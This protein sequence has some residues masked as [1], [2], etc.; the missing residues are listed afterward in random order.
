MCVRELAS[1]FLCFMAWRFRC[2]FLLVPVPAILLTSSLLLTQPAAA[3]TT[4]NFGP[5]DD[6]L[7]DPVV[8][9]AVNTVLR[10]DAVMRFTVQADIPAGEFIRVEIDNVEV[11]RLSGGGTCND[12]QNFSLTIP[13][14]TLAP[15]VA[16]GSLAI[17]FSASTP[18]FG[19]GGGCVNGIGPFSNVTTSFNFA[20]LGSLSFTTSIDRTIRNFVSRRADQITANEPNLASRLSAISKPVRQGSIKDTGMKLG[21]TN[22]NMTFSASLRNVAAAN[23]AKRGGAVRTGRESNGRMS[24]GHGLPGTM[25]SSRFDVWIEGKLAKTDNDTADSTLGLLY[26]GAD[27]R[28]SHSLVVGLL[29]QFDWSDE[30]DDAVNADIDG[31][32]WML[33]PYMAA[34]LHKNILF[35]SRIAWGRSD[36]DFTIGSSTGSFDTDRWLVKGQLTGDFQNNG[37]HLAPHVAVLYFEEDQ[38][39]T[40]DSLGNAIGAQ[41]V[42]L[43]RVTFG[44]KISTTLHS[45]NRVISPFVAV[46]GIWDFEKDDTV[47]AA[48][49]FAISDSD[50]RGRLEAG[51]SVRGIGG[52]TISGEGFYDGIGAKDF[53]A[54]GGS[55]RLTVPL[56]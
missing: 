56:R 23:A 55:L 51:A 50:F 43:G 20:L 34:R 45:G 52:I 35:D 10:S 47:N 37:W 12:L 24:L 48:S 53:D 4:V 15:L 46:K 27:Y 26:I 9:V 33:G 54:Y 39:A 31:R 17:R 32:G 1:R 18:G 6:S 25:V 38:D 42:K 16:D 36:N 11:G 3:Q 2:A 13:Q 14:A 5:V 30:E 7:I 28:L 22:G 21:A 8:N 29:G 41:T 40:T 19:G 49:G 44:P